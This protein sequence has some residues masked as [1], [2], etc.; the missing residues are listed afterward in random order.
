MPTWGRRASLRPAPRAAVAGGALAS[1]SVSV[2]WQSRVLAA[3]TR[4]AVFDLLQREKRAD[5]RGAGLAFL[6]AAREAMLDANAD[7]AVTA[8][9]RGFL[10]AWTTPPID[11]PLPT[12]AAFKERVRL[13]AA[14][15]D[16]PDAEIADGGRAVVERATASMQ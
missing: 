13:Y 6:S 10:D 3:G 9:A 1:L 7:P 12:E 16:I 11:L 4:S 15:A 14:L 5:R 8:A 2:A